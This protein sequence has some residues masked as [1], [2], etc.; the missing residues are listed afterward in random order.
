MAFPDRVEFS[1]ARIDA[2]M[3]CEGEVYRTS[4]PLA[5]RFG[6]ANVRRICGGP[7]LLLRHVLFAPAETRP[8]LLGLVLLENRSDRP[9]WVEHTELWDVRE[10]AY[11]CLPGACERRTNGGVRALA[12][13]AHAIQAHPPG[14]LSRGLA[15]EARLVLP[16]GA[17]RTLCFAYAAP[18]PEEDAG[19]LVRAWRGEIATELRRV[20]RGWT[21]RVGSGP[22]AVDAYRRIRHGDARLEGR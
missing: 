9:L 19:I 15:L 17:K 5:V 2:L 11:R 4:D 8:L 7:T 1:G 3:V 22:D 13:A 16:A 21:E 18:N 6:L 12:D 10:G 14:E 20:V